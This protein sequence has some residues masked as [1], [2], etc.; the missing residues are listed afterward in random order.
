MKELLDAL[1]EVDL[2]HSVS[3][4]KSVMN[5]TLEELLMVIQFRISDNTLVHRLVDS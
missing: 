3:A 1:K 2:F 5:N 4:A